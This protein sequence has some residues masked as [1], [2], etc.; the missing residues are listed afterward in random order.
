MVHGIDG[1]GKL[2][3]QAIA[4]GLKQPS[5]ELFCMG[6]EDILAKLLEAGQRPGFVRTHQPRIADHVGSQYRR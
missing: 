4:D 5:A 3:Q 2:D 1:A 6:I